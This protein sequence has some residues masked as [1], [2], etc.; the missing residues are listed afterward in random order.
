MCIIADGAAEVETLRGELSRSKE[1]ARVSNAA[2][3]KAAAD[4]KAE[5]ATRH[6]FK[7]RISAVEQ[8]LKDAARK[9]E[10]LEKENKAKATKLDK[11]LQE[12]KDARSESRAAREE[13][14]QAGQIAAGKPFLLQTKFGDQRYALLN[15]L[16]SSPD[17]LADLPKSASDAS[18]FFQAQEGHAMEKLFWS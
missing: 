18:Q 1:Q 6:L 5:Q 15:R 3:D 16:W 14:R 7:E 10:S 17:A 13:I 8:E 4:L 11:A 9:C 2:T 12:A